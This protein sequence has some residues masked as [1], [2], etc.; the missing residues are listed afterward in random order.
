MYKKSSVVII[1]LIFLLFIYTPIEADNLS[2]KVNY[3]E[4]IIEGYIYNTEGEPYFMADAELDVTYNN[5]SSSWHHGTFTNESGYFKFW[6]NVEILNETGIL[7][8]SILNVSSS[9]EIELSEDIEPIIMILPV[10]KIPNAIIFGCITDY[11][12]KPIEGVIVSE[13]YR[14]ISTITDEN[15]FYTFTNFTPGWI[16]WRIYAEGY[17]THSVHTGLIPGEL[18]KWYNWSFA[19]IGDNPGEINGTIV[20]NQTLEPLSNVEMMIFMD[21]EVITTFTNETGYYE[22]RNVTILSNGYQLIGAYPGYKVLYERVYVSSNVT[23]FANFEMKEET[24]WSQM[25]GFIYDNEGNPIERG[26]IK[27]ETSTAYGYWGGS[28]NTWYFYVNPWPEIWNFT[29]ISPGYKTVEED[30]VIPNP[31]NKIKHIMMMKNWTK[32]FRNISLNE[33]AHKEYYKR[34]NETFN[35]ETPNRTVLTNVD[36]NVIWE[37]DRTYGIFNKKG[38]DNL[39]VY[40]TYGN[41]TSIRSSIGF[42]NFSF[43]FPINEPP[44]EESILPGK[45]NA[46]LNIRVLVDIGEPRWRPIKYLL[47]RGNDFKIDFNLEYYEFNE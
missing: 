35:I 25:V 24:Y 7:T 11:A 13:P 40:F 43:S 9:I 38:L 6:C 4:F 17:H 14:D 44:L 28:Y 39:T 33:F 21:G 2:N 18:I 16:Y 36:I 22:F 19:T 37:D 8:A 47:D 12:L 10:V 3:N 46:S 26:T 31:G 29:F 42:G 15:G 23:T 41:Y 20:N 5:G 1:I 30:L 32:S 34:Y 27:T 45:N